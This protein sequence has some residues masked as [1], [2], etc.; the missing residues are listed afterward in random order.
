MYIEYMYSSKY[1]D[2]IFGI[3]RQAYSV[4]MLG[5]IFMLICVIF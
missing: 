5:M 2:N 1:I 4:E 3:I